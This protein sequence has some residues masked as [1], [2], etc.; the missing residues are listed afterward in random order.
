MAS[1]HN[2]VVWLTGASSG[3]GEALAYALAKEGAKLIISARRADELQRVAAKC[4]LAPDKILVLPLDLTDESTFEA[5]KA[6][7]LKKFSHIDTLIN[8]G[9]ISQRSLARDTSVAVDRS[10]MEVN[11]FGTIA[12][13]KTLLPDFRAQKS[14]LYVVVSSV[15]GKLG[16]PWRSGYSASKHALHGFFDSLRAEEYDSGIRVLLVCPGFIQ[17]NISMN[18]LT[19]SGAKLG[20]MD[21]AT[22][23]GLTADECAQQIITAI[24]S[25]KEEI[26][27]AK[28]RERFAVIAKRFFPGIFS[29]LIRG[30]AVR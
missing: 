30:M 1:I 25:D 8:N 23:K 3:I 17:T 9:G 10:I 4:N 21:S 15:V 16:S 29:R 27:V 28:I 2:Q 20:S 6:E 5:K 12:L 26:V 19:G 7:V 14:G 24:K 18:A 22:S 13:T 11:Y